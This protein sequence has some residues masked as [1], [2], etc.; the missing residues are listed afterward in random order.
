MIR[1]EGISCLELTEGGEI[2]IFEKYDECIPAE[3]LRRAYAL[4]RLCADEICQRVKTY[5][6]IS[7]EDREEH[8][9]E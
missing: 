5:G 7:E 6:R 4:D 9:V 2:P 3:L 1:R 8:G